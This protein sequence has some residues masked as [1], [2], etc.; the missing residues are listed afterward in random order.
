MVEGALS[1]K[2]QIIRKRTGEEVVVI[3]RAD[4]ERLRPTL[5]SY[6][7]QSA[8]LAGEDDDDL[9]EQAIAEVRASGSLGLIPR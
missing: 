8:G 9:L 1:G 7:L 6:L 4:Y 2:P 5:K 3:S